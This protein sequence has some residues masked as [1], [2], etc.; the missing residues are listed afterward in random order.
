M[1][2]EEELN[3][4]KLYTGQIIPV[5]GG[6]ITI[7]SID[8]DKREGTFKIYDTLFDA[9]KAEHDFSLAQ[10]PELHKKCAWCALDGIQKAM[11]DLVKKEIDKLDTATE[12]CEK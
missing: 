4:L 3:K 8:L 7:T 1:V 10:F 6:V 2:T 9:K 12:A 11:K 5:L